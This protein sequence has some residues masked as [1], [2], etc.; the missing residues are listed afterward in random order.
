MRIQIISIGKLK[1][2]YLRQAAEEYLKRL[3]SYARVEL[4][5]LAEE[6]AQ[7]PI[8]DAEIAQIL[9]KEGERI[10]RQVHPDSYLIALAIEGKSFSSPAFAG[11]LQQLITYGKSHITFVIGGSYGLSPEVLKRADLQLSFSK[12]T[13]PHQLIRIFLLE[14]IY[15]A[16]KINRGETYHK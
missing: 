15:R 14:Q 16:C 11:Q 13:F 7:E 12:M 8:Y 4:V 5:E 10:L 6:K 3:R 1:E 9:S 2:K